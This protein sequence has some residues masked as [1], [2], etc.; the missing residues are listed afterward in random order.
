MLGTLLVSVFF[1]VLC[2]V[3]AHAQQTTA[4][5]LEEFVRRT[6]QMDRNLAAAQQR[7]SEARELLRQAGARPAP[8]LD[9]SA[10]SARPF[11]TRGEEE[12]SASFLYQMETAGKR[13]ERLEVAEKETLRSPRTRSF[14]G[15]SL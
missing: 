1:L 12:Y 15:R 2:Y 4:L 5:S 3:P 13:G 14:G 10:S 11:R 8:I 7:V 9:I 6:L